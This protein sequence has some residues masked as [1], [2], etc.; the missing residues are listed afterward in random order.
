MLS[1]VAEI[2]G[3]LVLDPT[4][5]FPVL[6][7]WDFVC[8]DD[9]TF[10][11]LMNGLHSGMLGTED[12]LLDPALRPEIADTGH[13]SLDHRTRRGEPA[14]AWYRGPFVPQPTV[15]TMPVAGTLPLAHTGDQL[16]RVVPDGHEDLSQAAGFEIGRLLALSR[17]GVVAALARWRQELFGAARVQQLGVAFLD[18]ILAGFSTAAIAAPG[19][20]D[21]LIADRIVNHYT[22]GVM[23]QFTAVQSFTGSRQPDV[24]AQVKPQQ[25]LVGLGLDPA[26]V[27]Q[28]VGTGGLA[29]LSGIDVVTADMSREPL[30]AS[31]L[32][33]QLV[34]AA[35]SEHI[36]TVATQAVGDVVQKGKRRRRDPLDRLIAQAVAAADEQEE[37]S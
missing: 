33:L 1:D 29:G 10:E 3:F 9:G 32:D 5:R 18:S 23:K 8:T 7:S 12:E 37:R 27:K 30:S 15:R 2:G 26:V 19:S 25:V 34:R 17:P 11:I 16:R 35:L 36:E 22:A 13:I 24:V 6:T 14:E 28:A 4:Y 31:T 21:T 20:L